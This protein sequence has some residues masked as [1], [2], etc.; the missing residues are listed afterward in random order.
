MKK[1]RMMYRMLVFL[2][3][4]VLAVSLAACGSGRK[5]DSAEKETGPAVKEET[6]KAASADTAVPTPAATLTPT[7]T[8]E[9]TPDP[10]TEIVGTYHA[11]F[12]FKDMMNEEMGEDA[13]FA[14][15]SPI[16]A[17]FILDLKDDKSFLF[18][19]NEE[20]LKTSMTEALQT[21]GRKM[22]VKAL[23]DEGITEE[24]FDLVAEQSGYESYDAFIEAMMGVM[25]EAADVEASI[26]GLGDSSHVEGTY[27]YDGG[28]TIRFEP[29]DKE[30][31]FTEGTVDPDGAIRMTS[32]NDEFEIE[33]IF[34]KGAPYTSKVSGGEAED[35]KDGSASSASSE[36]AAAGGTANGQEEAVASAQ[37]YL[38]YSSFSRMGLIEQLSSE[39]GDGYTEE[40]ATSAVDYLEQNGL[41]DWDQ[42]AIEAAQSYLKNLE[43][44]HDGL[45]EQLT[46]EYGEYFTQEQA[47]QAV[48]YI[49]DNGLVDW[50]EE[51]KEAVESYLEYSDTTPSRE[52]LLNYLTGEYGEGFTQEQ[53]EYAL[54]AAG[55]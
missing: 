48:A 24:T 26:E 49:E 9:P 38:E 20:S 36:A 40:E 47:E 33:L 1:D 16:E 44:S 37:S 23:E 5:E 41:V 32:K 11:T 46:S 15:E 34:R 50:N 25:I 30:A 18:E 53:A 54:Q 4:C 29:K 19:A 7:A 39:Y 14:F 27:A 22:V 17:E 21:D 28:D 43:F 10:E 3:A 2:A 31:G 52:D 12:D 55:Y 45:I 13:G 35:E 6:E 42:E 51:A 8:P